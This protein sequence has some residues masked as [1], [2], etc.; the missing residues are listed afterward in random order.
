MAFPGLGTLIDA[1]AIVAGAGVGTLA[2]HRLPQRVREAV[3]DALGLVTAV[4]GALNLVSLTNRD[5]TTAV[6]A[7]GTTLVLLGAMVLGTLA[8]AA[9]H[10]EGRLESAGAWLQKRLLR[11]AAPGARAA[12]TEGFVS[13]SLVVAIGPLAILG[14]LS[15]GLGR[16][17]EQLVVKSAIDGTICVA[18]AASLGWGV[19][20]AAV[21]VLVVQGAVTVIGATLGS[22]MPPAEIAAI[23]AV[24]GVLLLGIGLRLMSIKSVPVANMLPAVLIAPVI[25]WLVPMVT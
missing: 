12:F 3:T 7:G 17:I 5:F 20:A 8:G 16:G 2:G 1:A 23:T 4:I 13:T 25:T 21:S 14:P 11:D 24:G 9:V 19:A 6:G 18:F 10:L 15:D 22:F